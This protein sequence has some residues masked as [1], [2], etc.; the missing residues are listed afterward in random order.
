MLSFI[1]S[2]RPLHALFALLAFSMA[3]T[4]SSF[5][6]EYGQGAIPCEM[7]WWQRYTHWALWVLSL[8][9]VFFQRHI[10]SLLILRLCLCVVLVSLTIGAYQGLGQ[11]GVIVLPDICGG[12]SSGLAEADELLA[13]L[14]TN[15]DKV[16][17]CSDQGFTIL[18]LTLAW[19]NV[20]VMSVTAVVMLLW[21]S[22]KKGRV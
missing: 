14:T 6:L 15:V 5:Y 2:I 22:N 19:W 4:L 8:V 7:C 21:M 3:L 12:S 11:L 17:S 20:I 13:L 16:P 10:S 1:K 18:N 9:G